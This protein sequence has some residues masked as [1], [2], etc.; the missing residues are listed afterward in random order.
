[1]ESPA[2]RS[3]GGLLALQ[4]TIPLLSIRLVKSLKPF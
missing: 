1:M 2:I 4:A 3:Y